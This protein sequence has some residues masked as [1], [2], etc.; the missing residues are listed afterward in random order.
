MSVSQ[1]ILEILKTITIVIVFKIS[2]MDCDIFGIQIFL[3]KSEGSEETAVLSKDFKDG[4]KL[5]F[6]SVNALKLFSLIIALYISD[7]PFAQVVAMLCLILM[8]LIAHAIVLPYQNNKADNIHESINYII[9]IVQLSVSKNPAKDF[10]WWDLD[11]VS[12]VCSL[13]T[14]TARSERFL[15]N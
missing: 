14:T 6:L 13:F 2:K 15:Q 12:V 9:Q 4:A 3:I 5:W 7:F 8:M 11:G 10:C 1:S